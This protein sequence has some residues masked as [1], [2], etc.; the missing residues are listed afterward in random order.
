MTFE[1][2]QVNYK[3]PNMKTF[4]AFLQSKGWTVE[5]QTIA[6]Y[7]MRAPVVRGKSQ[8][9]IYRLSANPTGLSFDHL[10]HLAVETF[11]EIYKI[12]LQEMFDML[13]QDLDAIRLDVQ[14]LPKQLKMKREM[15]AYAS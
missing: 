11:A 10:S 4:V 9:F 12:P 3:R 5:A 8:D 7:D 14:R 6:Y 13:S 2:P 15:L 1:P